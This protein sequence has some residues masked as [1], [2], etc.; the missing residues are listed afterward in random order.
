MIV[1]L[2]YQAKSWSRPR[3]VVV[4]IEWHPGELFPR[5]GFV[6]TNSR[7]PASKVIKV[8]NGPAQIENRVEEGQNTLRWHKTNCQRFEANQFRLRMG[9]PAYNLAYDPAVP[10]LGCRSETVPG[11]A[12]QAI[13]QRGRQ[14]FLSCPEMVCPCGLRLAIGSPLSGSAGLKSIRSIAFRYPR[15]EEQVC[16][17]YWKNY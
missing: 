11:V 10:C 2:R 3:R 4:K 9:V 17:I 1:D 5:I 15:F 6:V 7:L 16:P 13:N 12:D 8:Y 14:G